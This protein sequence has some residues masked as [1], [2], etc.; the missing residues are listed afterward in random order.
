[1]RKLAEFFK[2]LGDENRLKIIRMLS[3]KELCVCEIID[4]LELSQPAISHHLKI[5][6][7]AGLVKDTKEG[8]W[9]YY[10]L[11]KTAF[12]NNGDKLKRILAELLGENTH[13]QQFN[14]PK[15][16]TDCSLC[17]KLEAKQAAISKE[18]GGVK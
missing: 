8:K 7:Q 1:M 6:R 10:A 16:R 3:E 18:L 5:L 2:A 13:S 17:E 4:R 12:I 14:Q 9:V 11:N 15:S